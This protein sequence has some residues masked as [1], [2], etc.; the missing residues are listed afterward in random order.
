MAE[1]GIYFTFMHSGAGESIY[2]KPS[3]PAPLHIFMTTNV[4]CHECKTEFAKPLKEHKRSKKLGRPEFCSRS[5]S[6]SSRNK[7][8]PKEE[9]LKHCYQI[10][11]HSNNR[12]DEYSSFRYF[13]I[14]S[15][16]RQRRSKYGAST[17]D[18][19]YLKNLWEA[20]SGKCAYTGIGM[21]LPKNTKENSII[22][23]LKKASL[24]RIDSKK[25]YVQGNVQFVCLSLNI[26]K[27]DFTNEEMKSFL[28]EIVV[29]PGRIELPS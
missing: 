23:S 9:R 26:A 19:N 2:I 5:C 25:G 24:D 3:P 29:E 16:D 11:R 18:V 17:I 12:H 14:K 20:Q 4:K 1:I 21:I 15:R 10:K 22:R 6:A 28:S 7:N 8:W 27:K 13:I